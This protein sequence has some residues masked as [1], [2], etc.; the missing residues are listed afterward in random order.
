MP[1]E[2]KQSTIIFR[3]GEILCFLPI[4]APTSKIR[5]KRN[6]EPFAT[7]KNKLK[8]T[9]LIEWQISYYESNTNKKLVE[10]GKMLEIAFKNNLVSNRDLSEIK[11]FTKN[12]K[13]TFFEKYKFQIEKLKNKFY[14]F[15]I[16]YRKFPFIHKRLP[17]GCIIEVEIKHKQRAVGF[18]SM[19]YVFIPLKNVVSEDGSAIIGREAKRK[20]RVIWKPTPTD[21]IEII[22]TFAIASQNHL[23][24]IK[25]ILN[26]I[27][28]S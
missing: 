11:K 10:A 8:N 25:D 15:E 20:E 17:T 18:Q 28:K 26:R 16:L 2:Y 4:T 21:I 9:D 1:E 12:V 23:K 24:D 22:K 27:S 5:L 14:D 3:N 19:L 13:E 7:R 6:G